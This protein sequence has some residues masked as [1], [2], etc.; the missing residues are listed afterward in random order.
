MPDRSAI[1][2]AHL[3][4]DAPA[5][6]LSPDHHHRRPWWSSIILH[7]SNPPQN[8]LSVHFRSSSSTDHISPDVSSRNHPR[9][10]R[11]DTATAAEVP[12]LSSTLCPT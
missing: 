5:H 10:P 2:K 1:D 3:G 9:R 11:T 12:V 7:L 4:A 8:C 6:L